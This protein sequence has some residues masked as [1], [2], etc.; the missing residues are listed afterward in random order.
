VPSPK[1]A[2]QDG[3]GEGR[4][5]IRFTRPPTSPCPNSTLFGPF[6]TSMRSKASG[7]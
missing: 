3:T 7:S 2:P 6:S 4:S 5:V 1:V